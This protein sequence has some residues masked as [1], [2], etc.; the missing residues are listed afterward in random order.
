MIT[1]MRETRKPQILENRFPDY[2]VLS[3]RQGPSWNEQTREV[4]A[5]RLSI[6]GKPHFFTP[7]EFKTLIAIAAR[8]VPQPPTRPEIPVAA[9]IDDKLRQGKSEGYREASLPREPEAW[10][11]GLKALD[12]E[13]KSACGALFHML[14]PADQDVLLTRM[15]RGELNDSAWQGMPSAVFFKKRMTLDIVLA[16]YAHP[17]AW[18]EIGWGG[19][20]SPRGYVRMDYDERDPW[21][22]AEVRDGDVEAA[23][24]KNRRVR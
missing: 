6:D 7:E 3:K 13:A 20:A 18:D 10:R 16:Y 14:S 17:I 1:P 21:E 5:R 22:A 19:P 4:I 8:I 12:V 11:V 9:L 15:E 2:D 23:R 24:R